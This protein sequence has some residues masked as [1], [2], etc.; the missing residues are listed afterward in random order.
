[1]KKIIVLSIY[2]CLLLLVRSP[3]TNASQALIF[4][5]IGAGSYTNDY[6][7]ARAGGIHAAT[8]IFAPKGTPIVAATSG[9]IFYVNVPEA[10]WGYSVGIRDADG[11]LYRYIHMNND[12]PGT[13]DGIG[14]EMNAYAPDMKTGNKVE[15]GQLLGW[16]GDSGNAEISAPHLHFEIE[17]PDG[18]KVNPYDFLRQAPHTPA[19][20]LYPPLAGETLPYWV[21][22]KGGLNLAM[23]DFNGDGISESVTGAGAGG[24]PIVKTFSSTNTSLGEFYAY[25]PAFKGGIDV[26]TGDIDG[27]GKSEIIT[28]P[29]PGGGPWVRIF[30]TSAQMTGEF[31]AYDTEFKGGIHVS[32]GDVDG[33]GKDEII[34]GPG[35]GGGPWVRVFKANGQLVSQFAAYDPAFKGGIDISSADTAG[36]LS[37]EIITGPG[38][39]GGPWV[40]V[41]NAATGLSIQDIQVY[42]AAFKGGVRVSAGDVR[43]NSPK[44]EIL[45]IP[46]ENGEPRVRLMSNSGANITDYDYIEGWWR[47]NYDVA[48]GHG[49]SRVGTGSIRRASMRVGPN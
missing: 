34:T 29:G 9:T 30:N 46:W 44:S 38:P 18:S 33:D 5:L 3:A 7:S 22:F 24:S 25:D 21:D 39:G 15:K 11:Y 27:D 4:P 35:P 13:D 28:G 48:A 19:P 47:G 10:S 41:F 23:G 16:V 31:A 32:T 2:I 26:A 20:S 37:A 49:A 1:M 17:A 43:P 12:T 8:D 45:S 40:R 36:T 14:T 6:N 42:D